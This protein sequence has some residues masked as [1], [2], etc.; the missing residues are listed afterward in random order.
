MKHTEFWQMIARSKTRSRGNT[1]KQEV[2]LER[3]LRGLSAR[4]IVAFQSHFDEYDDRAY[5]WD[6]WGAVYIVYGGC[7][8]DSFSDFRSWLISRGEEVY[9]TVVRDPETLP[10]FIRPSKKDGMRHLGLQFL[11]PAPFVWAEKTGKD[12]FDMPS[13]ASRTVEPQGEEWAEDARELAQRFP[14]LWK[15]YGWSKQAR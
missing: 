6:I 12:I 2:F 13:R 8:D 3:E 10:R 14:T 7:S 4:E 11:N 15:R 5:H 9:R 1:R